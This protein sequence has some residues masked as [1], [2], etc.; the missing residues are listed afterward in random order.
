VEANRNSSPPTWTVLAI[1]QRTADFF[2]GRGIET[3]RLDAEL[4]LSQVLGCE[5]IQLYAT[6]D[7]PLTT[8]EVDA[9]RELVRKRSQRYP[10]HYLLGE[11]EFYSRP[12][13]VSPDVL[14]PR[15]E[16]E[17]LVETVMAV[18]GEKKWSKPVIAD[19]GTG[20]GNIAV[21][22]ACELPEADIHASDISKQALEVARAN[23][24]RHSAQERVRFHEG[25]LFSAFPGDLKGR[26]DFVVSNPPY[27]P[28]CQI[29]SLMP[30][31]RDHEPKIALA[32]EGDGLDFFRRIVGQ[33][34]EWLKPGGCLVL[35]L[36]AGQADG[37][38]SLVD[39]SQRYASCAVTK[40]YGGIERVLR[41]F[42]KACS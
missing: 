26:L 34:H 29:G 20:S 22:L 1:L 21:T 41:A 16:T 5:R 2:R 15:P 3:P 35:E 7:R 24:E 18:A 31:V 9:F 4:L 36:G 10:V 11:R 19:L 12:F 33:A 23:A 42:T 8:A 13:R 14:I 27:V 38:R 39:T 30:E 6:Y 37:V 32:V 17:L 25:D 40:D 28:A